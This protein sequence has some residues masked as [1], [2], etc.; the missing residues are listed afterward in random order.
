MDPRPRTATSPDFSEEIIRWISYN[1]ETPPLA[2]KDYPK[3][4]NP[5]N[6]PLKIHFGELRFV[7]IASIQT[8][9][10]LL[11]STGEYKLM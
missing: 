1:G 5:T 8:S 10:L 4:S 11:R 9:I 3:S 2:T 6:K 7:A